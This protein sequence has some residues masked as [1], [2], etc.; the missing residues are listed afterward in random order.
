MAILSLISL[1][2]QELYKNQFID[3]SLLLKNKI[4]EKSIFTLKNIMILIMNDL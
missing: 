1:N 2:K 4:C 3:S